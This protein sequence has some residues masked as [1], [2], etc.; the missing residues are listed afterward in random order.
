MDCY[1]LRMLPV[2]S[3]APKNERPQV[4]VI[5]PA[6]KARHVLKKTMDSILMQ[7]YGEWELIVLCGPDLPAETAG[8]LGEQT[9]KEK[10]IRVLEDREGLGFWKSL[11]EG[12]RQARGDYIAM[13]TPGSL[14]AGSR[15][16]RQAA[17]ME[18]R[19]NLGATQTYQHRLGR[20]GYS[21]C[22]SPVSPE[23]MKAKLLFFCDIFPSTVMLR[24]STVEEQ[25][26]YFDPESGCPDWEFWMRAA[27]VTDIETI[28]QVLSAEYVPWE[29]PVVRD[30]ARI[31]EE[32]GELAA[33]Q[34][35]EGLKLDLIPEK[36]YF[37][38]GWC[39][40]FSRMD[41][42]DREESLRELCEILFEIWKMNILE[43]CFVCEELVKAI[44]AKWHW[45]KYDRPWQGPGRNLGIGEALELPG[46]RKWQKELA[47]LWEEECVDK[48]RRSVYRLSFRKWPLDLRC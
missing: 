20:S 47:Q 10:R 35:K 46:S 24:K 36:R 40:V 12:M 4:S 19:P 37:L 11:N 42:L 30:D 15:L 1:E 16:R 38:G 44:D 48:I 27:G 43:Q 8:F 23:A 39:N 2:M 34:L 22:R 29:W 9:E 33:R 3:M 6:C 32:M 26:L 13:I 7:D 17:H 25:G 21:I 18:K 41:P 5:L 45:S 31:Q 14:A 28:P